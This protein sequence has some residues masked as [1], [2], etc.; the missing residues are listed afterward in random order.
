MSDYIF[1]HL[2]GTRDHVISSGLTADLVN[3]VLLANGIDLKS[4]RH[5]HISYQQ[6]LNMELDVHRRA[7]C[8][9]N[10]LTHLESS[11]DKSLF[12]GDVYTIRGT[13][14]SFVPDSPASQD[15]ILIKHRTRQSNGLY[16]YNPDNL[17]LPT[18]ISKADMTNMRFGHGKYF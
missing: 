18:Y 12:T 8:L 6:V 3:G 5:G 16:Y 7:I 17:R 1:I 15:F 10:N 11:L 14:Y 9:A 13:E 2:V 4:Y